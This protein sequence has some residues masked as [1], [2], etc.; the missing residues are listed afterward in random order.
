VLPEEIV[1]TPIPYAQD[2][3]EVYFQYAF[4]SRPELDKARA[5]LAAREA[6]VH[7]ARSNFYPKLFVGASTNLSG[8]EGRFRQPAPYVGDPFRARSV[9]A[10]FGLRQNVNIFQ[11]RARVEQATAERNQVR[12][13]QEGLEQLILFQVEEAYRNLTVARSS[14]GAQ[15]EALR[16]S[17]EWLQT[18]LIDFD[19]DLGDTENLVRAVQAGLQIEAQYYETVQRFNV[20][21][22]R[23]LHAAGLLAERATAGTFVE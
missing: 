10:G 13:Q 21:V 2:S 1:L 3:L 16:I 8:A 4:A 22:L 12:Y 11:T 17:K 14:L 9:R 6:L 20:A 5:G 18:E 7:V 15:T 19:L 23:L